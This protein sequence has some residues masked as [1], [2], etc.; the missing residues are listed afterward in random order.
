M[1]PTLNHVIEVFDISRDTL[2]VVRQNLFWAFFYKTAG[3]TLAVTGILTPI[4]AARAMVLLSLSVIANSCA[5]LPAF[6]GRVSRPQF[7]R[8]SL[9]VPQ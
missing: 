8:Q 5:R 3:I 1:T 2:P 6:P 4:L 7:H 9:C